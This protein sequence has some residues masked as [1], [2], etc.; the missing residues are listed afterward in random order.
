MPAVQD[1]DTSAAMAAAADTMGPLNALEADRYCEELRPFAFVDMGDARWVQQHEF[2]TQLNLQAHVNASQQRD[3]FVL[4]AFVLHEK[5][6]LLIRE[7][8]ACELWKQNAYPLLKGWLAENNSIKSYLLLYHEGVLVNLLEALLYHKQACDASGDLIVELVDYCHRKLM[9]LL[10]APPPKRPASAAELKE[11]I[12][13]EGSDEGHSDEQE[14]CITMSAALCALSI[15]RFLSDHL[16]ALPLAVTARILDTYDILMV[17]C[18]L[19]ENKPWLSENEEGEQR[20]F[21]QSQWSRVGEA[22]K[23]KMHK[24]EA[25]CWLAV[26]NLVLDPEMRR[27]YVSSSRF[28]YDLGEVD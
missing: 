16:A 13:K 28:T 2:L 6:P 23:R 15:T 7:L 26:Y 22:E 1:S 21:L 18:P 4:E 14:Y 3:E 17:L 8:V 25:Q 9:W 11:Q 24:A 5:L 20:R 27:R 12:L 19:L 10:N